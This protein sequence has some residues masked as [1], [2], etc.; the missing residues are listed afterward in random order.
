MDNLDSP[1]SDSSLEKKE[2]LITIDSI[3]L[4]GKTHK[5]NSNR[6][7]LNF[8]LTSSKVSQRSFKRKKLLLKLLKLMKQEKF[9]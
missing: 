8:E 3:F 1:K 5:N 6:D 4:E 9:F 2:D 7:S